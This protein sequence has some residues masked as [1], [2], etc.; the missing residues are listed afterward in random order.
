M[1]RSQLDAKLGYMLF[2]LTLG[3]NL[4]FHS[5]QIAAKLTAEY[6]TSKFQQSENPRVINAKEKSAYV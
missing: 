2:R 5:E 4:L 3:N 1:G 6:P